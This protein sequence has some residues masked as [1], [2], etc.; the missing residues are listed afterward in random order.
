ML[1]EFKKISDKVWLTDV[2]LTGAY[3][4]SQPGSFEL[5][6]SFPNFAGV[7]AGICLLTEF[8]MNAEFSNLNNGLRPTE[9]DLKSLTFDF[10]G[11]KQN[12]III[13]N[14]PARA[15]MVQS[16]DTKKGAYYEIGQEIDFTKSSI[17]VVQSIA[18]PVA[19]GFYVLQMLIFLE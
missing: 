2:P 13:E 6:A 19:P 5:G 7:V 11:K 17:N 8:Q 15:L 9:A 3:S 1:P 4:V 14:L 16:S 18:A 10:F 12:S